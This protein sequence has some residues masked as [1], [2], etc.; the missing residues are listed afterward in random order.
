VSA[1]PTSYSAELVTRNGKRRPP[2]PSIELVAPAATAE[3]AAAIAA[4]L[5]R[6]LHDT[7]PVL[8]PAGPEASPWER[9]ALAEGVG[10]GAAA[11]WGDTPGW[12]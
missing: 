4:A 9:A 2:R 5:E 6:F 8:Q 11:P 10:L 3:E 12:E 1:K 7:A